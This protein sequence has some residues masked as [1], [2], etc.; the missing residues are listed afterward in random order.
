MTVFYTLV[1]KDMDS[2]GF[3]IIFMIQKKFFIIIDVEPD[4]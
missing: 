2:Q 4:S 3:A 1:Q